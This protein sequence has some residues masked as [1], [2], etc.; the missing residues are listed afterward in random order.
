MAFFSFIIREGT[1]S[2]NYVIEKVRENSTI[3]KQY[4]RMPQATYHLIAKDL[5]QDDNAAQKWNNV[6]LKRK[7]MFIQESSRIDE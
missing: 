3:Y 5:F 2:A 1:G 4:R 7:E 6:G